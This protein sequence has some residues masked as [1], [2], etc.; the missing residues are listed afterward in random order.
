[1]E[2][3]KKHA[4]PCRQKVGQPGPA[5]QDQSHGSLSPELRGSPKPTRFLAG[6]D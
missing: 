6:E 5:A 4:N 3:K 1:M 2:E